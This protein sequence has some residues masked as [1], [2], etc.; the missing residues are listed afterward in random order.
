MRLVSENWETYISRLHVRK[1]GKRFLVY[2]YIIIEKKVL[3][4][5]SKTETVHTANM[6]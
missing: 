5:L 2:Q 4:Y 6:K 1:K 3:H